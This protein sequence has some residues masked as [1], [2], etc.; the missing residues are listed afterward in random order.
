MVHTVCRWHYTITDNIANRSENLK[1][2]N[3]KLKKWWEA[4][5]NKEL[6]IS[7]NKTEYTKFN[8]NKNVINGNN[9]K[10]WCSE[11]GW[12]VKLVS[13]FYKMIMA[14]RKI[15]TYRINC[16]VDGWIVEKRQAFFIIKRSQW[17]LKIN[18]IR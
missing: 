6:R 5:K 8:N 12:E 2:V 18:F 15:M 10:W 17:G 4:F 9:D 13:M 14:L 16:D 11:W 7:R 3:S 1:E